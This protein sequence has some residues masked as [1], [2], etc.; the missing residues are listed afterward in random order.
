MENQTFTSGLRRKP[1]DA[2]FQKLLKGKASPLLQAGT[3]SGLGEHAWLRQRKIAARRF[4]ANNTTGISD[5]CLQE[6]EFGHDGALTAGSPLRFPATPHRTYALFATCR[7]A[8]DHLGALPRRSPFRMLPRTAWPQNG[9]L[10][11]DLPAKQA[12][13]KRIIIL[14]VKDRP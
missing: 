5:N 8:A 3:L 11:N 10:R 9:N 1:V 14:S 13:V 4:M 2:L 7:F 6:H 12:A